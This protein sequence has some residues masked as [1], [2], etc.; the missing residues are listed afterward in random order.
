MT[1][2][3]MLN[4]GPMRVLLKS[5]LRVKVHSAQGL[6]CK[7]KQGYNNTSI[8]L[9]VGEKVQETEIAE[10]QRAPV[11]SQSFDFLVPEPKTNIQVTAFHHRK[12]KKE[13][14]G[15]ILIS[16]S[17]ILSLYT[18]SK[19]SAKETVGYLFRNKTDLFD[20]D[21]GEVYISFDF[22]PIDFSV[23]SEPNSNSD[24][25]SYAIRGVSKKGDLL[26]GDTPLINSSLSRS[27]SLRF[28]SRSRPNLSSR[29]L[30]KP[31]FDCT[32]ARLLKRENMARK[33]KFREQ[34]ADTESETSASAKDSPTNPNFSDSD[35]DSLSDLD[36]GT[37][38]VSYKNKF[39]ETNFSRNIPMV[40]GSPDGSCSAHKSKELLTIHREENSRD[41][42]PLLSDPAK[43]RRSSSAISVRVNVKS[44]TSLF[45]P[46]KP[47][48]NS[49]CNPSSQQEL[50]GPSQSAVIT[51]RRSV[52][53]TS[54]LSIPSSEDSQL[55]T[56]RHESSYILSP[57]DSKN[58]TNPKLS[59]SN[60][61]AIIAKLEAKELEAD[62][63]EEQTWNLSSFSSEEA[64][65]AV[66]LRSN[67]KEK[68]V[69]IILKLKQDYSS[70]ER[71][72]IETQRYLDELLSK[73]M[74]YNPDLLCKQ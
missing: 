62:S 21:R 60:A 22:V 58:D 67:S 2:C 54:K 51:G 50:A 18:S 16:V 36:C 44:A 12:L 48:T 14:L 68:L 7:Q 63:D 42:S 70:L 28:K 64:K 23:P 39:S 57:A 20:K 37:K 73:I 24:P 65:T 4:S 40:R 15:R 17:D 5:K 74:R 41:S 11:W 56:P 6:V 52:R 53:T 9:K 69:H 72:H 61:P 43:L 66:E 10:K 55:I 3:P 19:S 35:I 26:S 8:R 46:L 1:D 29:D 27:Q 59:K 13:F 49:D 47:S 38:A 33:A 34:W 25:D 71:T 32:E 45:K 31:S 30:I